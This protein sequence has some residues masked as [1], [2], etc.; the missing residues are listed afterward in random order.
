MMLRGSLLMAALVC[1][2]AVA[3]AHATEFEW[4][5]AGQI[6]L[7]RY[8]ASVAMLGDGRVLMAGGREQSTQPDTAAAELYDPR[9]NSWTPAPP[10]NEPR[11][12]ATAVTLRDG[13]VLVVG[14]RDQADYRSAELFNPATA[15]WTR[16]ASA[17]APHDASSAVVLGDGRV[18]FVG[19]HVYDRQSGDAEIYDPAAD[20]WSVTAAMRHLGGAGQ[21]VAGLHDGR[22]L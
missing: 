1:A 12:S 17:N 9:T 4:S 22:V 6:G 11:A 19:G 14:G 21:A 3:P 16:A 18:L 13:R 10:M 20:R 15:N 2:T 7:P 8:G 5:P